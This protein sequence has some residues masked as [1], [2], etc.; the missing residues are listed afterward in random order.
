MNY[1][2]PEAPPVRP[3]VGSQWY[4]RKNDVAMLYHNDGKWHRHPVEILYC[5]P[6]V[7][8]AGVNHYI[9]EGG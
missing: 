6:Y 2:V 1:L 3:E 4:D 9:G 5:F 7:D 8:D